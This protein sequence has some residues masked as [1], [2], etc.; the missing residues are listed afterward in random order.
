MN[1]TATAYYYTTGDT[2]PTEGSTTCSGTTTGHRWW[3]SW[4]TP[5]EYEI[6]CGDLDDE[7]SNTDEWALIMMKHEQAAAELIRPR[8]TEVKLLERRYKDY[9]PDSNPFPWKH[10]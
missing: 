4:A 1:Y 2:E 7:V 6:I 9:K 10:R 5:D 3:V 8:N